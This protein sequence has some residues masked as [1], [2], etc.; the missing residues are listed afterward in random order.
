MSAAHR[1]GFGTH[2]DHDNRERWVEVV[3]GFLKS[4]C[5]YRP[6]RTIEAVFRDSG[7]VLRHAEVDYITFRMNG[8]YA[9]LVRVLRPSSEIALRFLCGMVLVASKP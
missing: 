8:R 9:R 1:L 4:K 6:R 7:F 5:F 2:R 3:D